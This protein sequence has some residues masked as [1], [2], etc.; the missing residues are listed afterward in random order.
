MARLRRDRVRAEPCRRVRL[1]VDA[2]LAGRAS[3]VL[4]T[5]GEVSN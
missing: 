3:V 2:L 1:G 4:K 5:L